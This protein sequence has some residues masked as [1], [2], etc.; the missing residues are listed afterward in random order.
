M[1]A[2]CASPRGLKEYVGM[3][4]EILRF[5]AGDKGIDQTVELSFCANAVSFFYI[6]RWRLEI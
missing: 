4:F 5:M 2:L 3:F 6:V 1:S